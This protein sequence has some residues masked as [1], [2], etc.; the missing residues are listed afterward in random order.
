MSQLDLGEFRDVLGDGVLG[1]RHLFGFK[2]LTHGYSTISAST[3]LSSSSPA[4]GGVADE[5]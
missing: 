2:N 1:R 3:M 4:G 5:L